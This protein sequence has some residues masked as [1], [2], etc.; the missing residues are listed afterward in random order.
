MQNVTKEEFYIGEPNPFAGQEPRITKHM[1]AIR[2]ADTGAEM[3]VIT[4]ATLTTEQRDD[5]A[6]A[7]SAVPEMVH[8][9]RGVL[10]SDAFSQLPDDVRAAVRAAC[11]KLRGDS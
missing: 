4:R 10:H 6:K 1:R 8:A 5:M 11:R 3:A 7:F 9:V 2:S